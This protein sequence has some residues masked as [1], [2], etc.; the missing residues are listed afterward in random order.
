MVKTDY[1]NIWVYVEQKGGEIESV[2]LELCSEGRKLADSCGERLVAVVIGAQTDTACSSVEETGVDEIIYVKGDEYANYT[3]DP[4]V[5][6]MTKLCEKY[7]PS[8]VLIGA[9]SN[10]RDLAPRLAARLRTGS[11][12]DATEIIFN[13]ETEDIDWTK[14]SFGG[15]L[16]ATIV[17]NKTR[18]QIG[19]VRPATFKRAFPGKKSD[20]ILTREDISVPSE[21]IR[22]RVLEFI[23]DEGDDGSKIEEADVVICVGAGL[24]SMD[25]ISPFQELADLLGGMIGVTRPLVDKG[26]YT[27]KRQVGQSGKIIGPKLYIGFGISGAIQHTAGI[28]SSEVIVAVN[29]NPNAKIFGC[30][31]Y[32]VVGDMFEVASAL[33]EELKARRNG[34]S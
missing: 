9:T 33:V 34:K 5:I 14:P 8:A 16:M 4:Y 3:T 32:A 10:G 1:K 28:T 25:Q 22:T 12:A 18:P 26:F 6:A 31:H 15:N 23:K 30:A 13:P 20:L 27:V 11:T 17:C 29:N 24:K 7:K 2:S 19:T 21:E